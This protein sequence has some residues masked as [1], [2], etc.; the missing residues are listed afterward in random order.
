ML[1]SVL[2]AVLASD[3]L[4]GNTTFSATFSAPARL[5]L[6]GD[7]CLGAAFG[8]AEWVLALAGL[9]VVSLA[10]TMFSPSGD[11]GVFGVLGVFASL[12]VWASGVDG[13]SVPLPWLSAAS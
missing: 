4:V 13:R 6:T 3:H 7:D 2:S 12:T 5:P 9:G 1:T 10:S 11:F 8:L